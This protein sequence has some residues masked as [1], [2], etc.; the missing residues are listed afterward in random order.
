M[1]KIVTLLCWVPSFTALSS[2]PSIKDFMQA[3]QENPQETMDAIPVKNGAD[4][5]STDI[6]DLEF[7]RYEVREKIIG[8]AEPREARSLSAR[9]GNDDPA[10]LVDLGQSLIRNL[11]ELDRATPNVKRL[12]SQPWSDTY[13]PLYSGAAAWRYADRELRASTWKQYYDFSYVNKPVDYY[14]GN[15]RDDLS[16]SE[17]Y[18][19]LVGDGEFT[20]TKKSWDSGRSYYESNG[21]VERWMGLCH[22]WAAAAYMLPRPQKTVLVPDAKGELIKFYPSDIKALGTL[23]WAEAPFDSKFIGGRCNIKNP[24]KDSNGRVI[25]PNCHDNNPASWHLSVLNQ[26]GIS[27]RSLIMDATFDYQVWNQ[28][29]LGYQVQYF[30]PQTHRSS[31]NLSEV[32]IPLQ[33]YRDDKF[34]EYRASNAEYV[35]GVKMTVDYMVETNPTHRNSDS[36]NYD[37]VTR[38]T[39]FYDLELDVNGN[40]IGGEWYQNRH[41]DFLWTPLPNEE[42]QSYYDGWGRWDIS[43]PVPQHWQ[44]QA[45]KAARYNQPLTSVVKALF[46]AS[47]QDSSQD[48]LWKRIKTNT[49]DRTQCLDVEVA[50]TEKG[51]GSNVFGWRCHYGQNQQ[52]KLTSSG[53]LINRATPELCLDQ[54]GI[55]ITMEL[56]NNS[57]TQ[58]WRWSNGQLKNQLD[59]ALKWNSRTWLVEADINGS[60]WYFE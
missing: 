49:S 53:Q 17:K 40:V 44:T 27:E 60:Q 8:N 58:K 11:Y 16:P 34:S 20:L 51:M 38:V 5:P 25:D 45:P 21:H 24:E 13:W 50:E 23:L 48:N 15:S 10:R 26:L 3:F 1:N 29:L 55:Y 6:E 37:G 35:V 41:P 28:P 33:N 30:D 22:G 39:Y 18:D 4:N 57:I 14:Q 2:E 19:L 54:K 52:W 47:S 46:T 32:V 59:N 9:R 42:A 7:Y 36:P 12:D 43:Q 56:C 31:S